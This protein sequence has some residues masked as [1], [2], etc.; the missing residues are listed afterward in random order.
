MLFRFR[1][2]IKKNRRRNGISNNYPEIP[3]GLAD[4]RSIFRVDPERSR[5]MTN[6]RSPPPPS[7]V[8]ARYVLRARIYVHRVRTMR[9][10]A[11]APKHATGWDKTLLAAGSASRVS[12]LNLAND[13]RTVFD[14]SALFGDKKIEL[15][16]KVDKILPARERTGY[17]RAPTEPSHNG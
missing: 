12:L 7:P 17:T 1:Y 6:L 5:T 8:N 16:R 13:R 15:S 14:E 3:R 2:K 11:D 10:R 4:P 9:A